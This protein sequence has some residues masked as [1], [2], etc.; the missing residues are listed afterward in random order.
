MERFVDQY[1][2]LGHNYQAMG[3]QI[4]D[5]VEITTMLARDVAQVGEDIAEVKQSVQ[6]LLQQPRR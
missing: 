3:N 2:D 4:A 6:L 1:Q 5:L